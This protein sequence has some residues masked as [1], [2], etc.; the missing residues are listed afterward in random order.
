MESLASAVVVARPGLNGPGG[1]PLED[2]G[3]AR[4]RALDVAPADKARLRASIGQHYEFVWRILR[5]FGLSTDEA[6]DVTQE[7]FTVFAA[8]IADVNAGAEKTFLFQTARNLAANARRAR[9][10]WPVQAAEGVLETHPDPNPTPESM[11][12]E[13]QRRKLL[14][15]LLE[16]LPDD[17]RAVIVLCEL[18][19]TT[20]AEAAVILDIPSGTVASRLRRARAQLASWIAAARRRPF[21]KETP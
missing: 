13:G 10:R 5:R 2:V 11:A 4:A 1:N 15:E 18:E 12:D 20:F 3:T 17:L 8:R 19:S 16:R 7:V 6:D 21:R 9:A 14:D